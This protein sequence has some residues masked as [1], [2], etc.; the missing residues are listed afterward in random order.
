VRDA[1]IQVFNLG[2]MRGLMTLLPNLLAV[3]V[4]LGDPERGERLADELQRRMAAVAADIP[5]TQR[6]R[7]L[8]VSAYAG[9]AVWRHFAYELSGHA[10]RGRFDRCRRGAIP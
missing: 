7:A 10:A 4:L 5:R 9:A 2:E 6:K 8:Y 1:G 3:A